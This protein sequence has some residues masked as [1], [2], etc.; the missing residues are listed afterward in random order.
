[1]L[2]VPEILWG[3]KH[4]GAERRPPNSALIPD[5]ESM[6]IT[7]EHFVPLHL[8]VISYSEVVTGIPNFRH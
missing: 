1:M 4:H 5:A 7:N 6:N 3:P 2:L 8:G